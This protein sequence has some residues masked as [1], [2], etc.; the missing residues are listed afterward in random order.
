MG[1]TTIFDAWL[2]PQIQKTKITLRQYLASS[3]DI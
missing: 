1:T 2:T 3:E